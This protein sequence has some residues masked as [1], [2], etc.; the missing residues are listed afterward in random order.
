MHKYGIEL[1]TSIQ[2]AY[3]ID[4][5]NGDTFWRDAIEKEMF[6]VGIAFQILDNNEH[7]PVGYKLVTGNIAFD[8]KMDFTH[9]ARWVLDGH[10]TGTPS[11]S[12]Y[13]GIVSRESVRIALTYAA[14]ND[15]DV[16]AG[17]I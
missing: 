6:N 2:H 1:P 17:D 14:L 11:G 12:T 13:A 16:F 8:V 10:K 5:R 9:K 7:L 4:A 3:E 15:L